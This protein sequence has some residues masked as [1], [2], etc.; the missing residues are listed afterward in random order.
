MGKD[1]KKKFKEYLI[2]VFNPITNF[3]DALMPYDKIISKFE[4]FAFWR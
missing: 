4:L 2:K 1:I 3:D